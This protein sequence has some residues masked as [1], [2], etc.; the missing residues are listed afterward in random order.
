VILLPPF[1]VEAAD[2][3]R[4][5]RGFASD[6]FAAGVW[7]T[8]RQPA[9]DDYLFNRKTANFERSTAR[10]IIISNPAAGRQRPAQSSVNRRLSL[11][12]CKPTSFAR[13]E[14]ISARA[15]IIG[16]ET[17]ASQRLPRS[18]IASASDAA[19]VRRPAFRSGV[20]NRSQFAP[21]SID[22]SF[23]CNHRRRRPLPPSPMPE[24][25]RRQVHR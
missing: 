2:L 14:N 22:R 10:R 7:R 15:A 19:L 17:N 9:N 11:T 20:K 4:A 8:E 1:R 23:V 5:A 16:S 13:S 12:V 25:L 6:F 21:L 3:P 18:C 24:D